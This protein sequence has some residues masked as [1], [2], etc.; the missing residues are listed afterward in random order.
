MIVNYRAGTWQVLSGQS[1]NP[2]PPSAP[3]T[4]A[5]GTED[6]QSTVTWAAPL[7]TGGSAITGFTIVATPTNGT[8]L[9][10]NKTAAAGA[11]SVVVDELINDIGYTFTVRAANVVGSSSAGTATATPTGTW[12]KP[13][14]YENCGVPLGV[15]SDVRTPVTL[16]VEGTYTGTKTFNTA[17]TT[18]TNME[19][20]Y[21]NFNIKKGGITFQSCKFIG[22]P[23]FNNGFLLDTSGVLVTGSPC[24]FYD[25]EIDGNGTQG[26]PDGTVAGNGYAALISSRLVQSGHQF[27]RC[28]FRRAK[29]LCKL[30]SNGTNTGNYWWNKCWIGEHIATY[31]GATITSHSDAT[32]HDGG[33]GLRNFAMTGCVIDISDRVGGNAAIQSTTAPQFGNCLWHKNWIYTAA[34]Y[35]MNGAI[36]TIQGMTNRFINNRFGLGC[37]TSPYTVGWAPANWTEWA[38]NVWDATGNTR[39]SGVLTAVTAGQAVT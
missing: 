2:S 7:A 34:I 1:R 24:K 10:V 15:G 18:Y 23:S 20:R 28:V 19:F 3:R 21:A 31:S 36:Y 5:A 32:Q 13:I 35:H 33:L 17:D 16:T 9:V 11:V 8:G 26:N 4:V 37:T 22:S 25:C 12:T 6:G 38:G 27:H 14:K 30:P 39:I 29:D